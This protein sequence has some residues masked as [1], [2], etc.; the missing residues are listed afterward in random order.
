[1]PTTLNLVA[2][3][4]ESEFGSVAAALGAEALLELLDERH[5]VYEG[6]SE[7]ATIR[8]RGWV[9]SRFARLGP[10]DYRLLPFIQ[11]ELE[12]G[13]H[14]YSVAAAAMVL[15]TM[16]AASSEWAPRVES[17]LSRIR[18]R[19]DALQFDR[20][21]LDVTAK[22]RTTAVA[23]LQQTLTRLRQ[24]E[25]APSPNR[26]QLTTLQSFRRNDSIRDIEF[27]D[28]EG[29]R[30]T[31]G[32]FFPGRPSFLIFF[33]TRCNNPNK[34][35]ANVTRWGE[36][37]RQLAARGQ[38]D[39][40]NLAAI[41]YDPA[42]DIPARLLAYA[43]DRGAAL[44]DRARVFR[45]PDRFIEFQR[46]FALQ[47]NYSHTTVNRHASEALVLDQSGSVVADFIRRAWDVCEVMERLLD[48]SR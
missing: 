6:R 34:C 3:T 36:V 15:R 8:M 30:L 32:D 35:S 40:V 42:F 39:G 22:T 45:I 43:R 26:I 12:T 18:L 47:V 10:A 9:L 13:N 44:N 28:H 11:E 31:Y 1:V 48:L 27:E 2:S 38:A 7:N 20:Y 37:Q 23:E 41:T 14:A 24:S 29:R 25:A 4:P 19:D 46:H 17:A 21:P 5:P 16:E 33:Y